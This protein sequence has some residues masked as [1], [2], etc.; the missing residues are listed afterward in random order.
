VIILSGKFLH[1]ILRRHF[2]IWKAG[3]GID[4]SAKLILPQRPG[5]IL[6]IACADARQNK[7][8]VV[9]ERYKA[10]LRLF[11]NSILVGI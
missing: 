3:D 5:F 8:C 10:F 4:Q 9:E 1:E 7:Y 11:K 6:R 2:Q